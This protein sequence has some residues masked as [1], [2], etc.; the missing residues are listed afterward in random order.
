[1]AA[2]SEPAKRKPPKRAETVKV[3]AESAAPA[4]RKTAKGKG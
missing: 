2:E 1:V 4:A 3:A